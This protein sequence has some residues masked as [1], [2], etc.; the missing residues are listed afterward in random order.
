MRFALT[1]EQ[2]DLRDVVH[3][4]VERLCPPAVVRSAPDTPAVDELSRAL[5]EVGVPGLLLP[6][7]CVMNF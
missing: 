6:E 7:R 2:Q 4:L 1:A 5:A 3:E